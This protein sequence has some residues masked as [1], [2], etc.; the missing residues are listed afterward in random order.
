MAGAEKYKVA[1]AVHVN[2]LVFEAGDS[3]PAEIA[4][5]ITNPKV[6]GGKVPSFAKGKDAES[7]AAEK[8]AP[9][10][11]PESGRGSGDKAWVKYGEALGLTVP[12]DAK[13]ADV[14][15]LI[16]EQENEGAAGGESSD[17]EETEE[18]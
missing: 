10:A 16:A 11:P 4:K 12:A 17:T 5:Q 3:V 2:G 6:W 14:Q 1:T 18:S 9:Q 15:A 7:E 13:K 8:Q